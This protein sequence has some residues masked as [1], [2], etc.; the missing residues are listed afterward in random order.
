MLSS[1]VLTNNEE[2]CPPRTLRLSQSSLKMHCGT[3]LLLL[4]VV[5]CASG[6]D[7]DWLHSELQELDPG[8]DLYATNPDIPLYLFSDDGSILEN[9]GGEASVPI[10][11]AAQN[12]CFSSQVDIPI[13]VRKRDSACSV[14]NSDLPSADADVPLKIPGAMRV[15]PSNTDLTV[16]CPDSESGRPSLPVCSSGD[17]HDMIFDKY[18]SILYNY[19]IGMFVSLFPATIFLKSLFFE[20]LQNGSL[21]AN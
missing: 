8:S 12:E 11:V 17:P 18:N 2:V 19:E 5:F 15:I 13:R 21:D 4:F 7:L 20:L 10:L 1:A 16:A 6:S 3:F 9:E 14:L